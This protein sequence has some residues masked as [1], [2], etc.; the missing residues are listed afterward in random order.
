MEKFISASTL[1]IFLPNYRWLRKG[2]KMPSRCGFLRDGPQKLASAR[3]KSSVEYP[4]FLG[5]STRHE[6]CSAKVKG[7][8]CAGTRNFIY[9][10]EQ[11]YGYYKHD[12]AR[13]CDRTSA[14]H[15]A[16]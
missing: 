7:L 9:H 8:L 12:G 10:E 13:S 14:I 4:D 3:L 2:L 11:K 6:L 15:P 5:F 1:L 16:L